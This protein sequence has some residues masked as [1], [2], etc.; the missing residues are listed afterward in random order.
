MPLSLQVPPHWPQ[1]RPSQIAASRGAPSLAMSATAFIG[2]SSLASSLF[3]TTCI[4][5]LHMAPHRPD[6]RSP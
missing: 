3:S 2:A 1:Q 4:L 6:Q 5:S